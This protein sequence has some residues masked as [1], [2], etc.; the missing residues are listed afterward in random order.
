MAVSL[1]APDRFIGFIPATNRHG[2][3]YNTFNDGKL[4]PPN[5]RSRSSCSQFPA[6]M[7]VCVAR[8]MSECAGGYVGIQ[9]YG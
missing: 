4:P 9:G 7:S 8:R 3:W 5:S 2:R 1:A 6:C